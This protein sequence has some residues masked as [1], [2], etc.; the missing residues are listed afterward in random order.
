MPT[1]SQIINRRQQQRFVNRVILHQLGLVAKCDDGDQIIFT[2]AVDEDTGGF[3]RLLER[4]PRHA[5]AHVDHQHASEGEIIIRDVFHADDLRDFRQFAR[6]DEV[7]HVQALQR[8]TKKIKHIGGDSCLWQVR[9]I[10]P[11]N[12]QRKNRRGGCVLR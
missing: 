11:G 6:Q 8:L 2:Q 12:R 7:A 4:Q 1:K 5:A 3:L 9:R 10:H